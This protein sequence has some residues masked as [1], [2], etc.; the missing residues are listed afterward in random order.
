MKLRLFILLLF[1]I[2]SSIYAQNFETPG[3]FV[4]KGKVLNFKESFIDFALSSYFDGG[5]SSLVIMPDGSFNQKFPIENRQS[6]LTRFNDEMF[7]FSILYKDTIYLNWDAAN[8]KNTFS[9]RGK[10]D[11]RTKELQAQSKLRS[12]LWP[13]LM[14]LKKELYEK[15]KELTDEKR[16][17]LVNEA[18]NRN[19]QA[20]FDS[21]DFFSETLNNMIVSLYFQYSAILWSEHL[22][23]AYTL[24]LTL[25]STRSYP[26]FDFDGMF[27]YTSY[28]SMN[29]KWFWNVPEYRS[30]IYNYV[31][32]YMPFDSWNGSDG[33][34][35]KPF[36][37]T[38][39]YYYLAQATIDYTVIKDWFI[40]KSIMD[41]LGLYPFADVEKPYKLFMET[42]ATPFLKEKVQKYYEAVVLL[43]PGNTA[44]GFSLKNE[45][46]KNVSLND[47]KGK[48]VYIDFWGVGCGPC[49]YA[50]Q[51]SVPKLHELYK[52]KEV[53]FVNIC[54]DANEMQWNEALKK[55]N[56][57]GVNLI[58][59]GWANNPVC[60]AYNITGIPH[61]ILIDKNGN[62][63]D[64]NAPG[65]DQ[66]ILAS[67]T[68]A[69]DLLLK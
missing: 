37:P 53:V 38:L 45:I 41:G 51:N 16:F 12:L 8:F 62:I 13:P 1:I 56:L 3:Y 10:N 28:R 61:Y 49:I 60:K 48:V 42:C 59:K 40:A 17:T 20:I 31:R 23:P 54:V 47:F 68:N 55:Y 43:K 27:K 18:Y 6:M 50:I 4:I 63:A 64:N 69:I 21:T 15:R 32:F 36:N 57:T 5:T 2:P 14:D 9:I 52:N 7:Y 30:F 19:V 11:L 67:G 44:P 39:D 65:P 46:A 58:A 33:A 24:K 26:H 34:I 25:D 66:F 29:D 22:L 35:A